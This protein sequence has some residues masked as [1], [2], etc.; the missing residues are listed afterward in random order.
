[1]SE[2]Q[3]IDVA[4]LQE[5]VPGDLF[6]NYV[7]PVGI[8]AIAMAG[9]IGVFKSRNIIWGA[10]KLAANEL[11]GGQKADSGP[12]ERTQR[13]MP[14][15]WI[16]SLTVLT[17][18]LVFLFFWF[19]VTSKL[20]WALAG[21]LIVMVISFLFTTVAARAIATA[22]AAPESSDTVTRFAAAR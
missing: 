11:S 16:T 4:E 12:V 5:M 2:W 22:P 19:G 18:A 20:G 6:F 8:G 13:D 10:F 1:M 14:M 17:L 9:M 15:K 3:V 21:L 7:R